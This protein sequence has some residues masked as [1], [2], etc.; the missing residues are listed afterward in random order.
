[1]AATLRW[2]RDEL[3]RPR[4]LFIKNQG[5]WLQRVVGGYFTYHAMLTNIEALQQF[6]NQ[7]ARHW[8]R[9]FRRRSQKDRTSWNRMAQRVERWLPVARI[10]HPW[11][12]D[13]FDGMTQ[14]GS[15]AHDLP[16]LE[17]L[18]EVRGHSTGLPDHTS[19]GRA[20]AKVVTGSGAREP[21]AKGMALK[22][23]QPRC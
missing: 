8:F 18:E 15:H 17:L 19:K 3:M 22:P 11:P 13:R 9:A 16:A 21:D 12:T 23:N 1:M 20:L 14:G 5:L 4:H 10:Q 2:V 7:V 6:R